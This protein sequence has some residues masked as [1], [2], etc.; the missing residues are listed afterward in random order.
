M[1]RLV[2]DPS[3]CVLDL[4]QVIN[5]FCKE[6][7]SHDLWSLLAPEPSKK[8]TWKTAPDPEWL[9]KISPFLIKLVSVVKNLVVASKK[10]K[11][12][13]VKIQPQEVSFNRTFFCSNPIFYFFNW[14]SLLCLLPPCPPV[15]RTTQQRL[16]Y[17]KMKDEQF[18]D[19]LDQYI[20]IGAAQIRT[21]KINQADFIRVAKK[22]SQEEKKAIE[23][24]LELVSVDPCSLLKFINFFFM[25]AMSLHFLV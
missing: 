20:R 13:M 10:L 6:K 23:E 4:Q 11:T 16:N 7:G 19:Q 22:C 25:I 18:F 1:G 24:I 17:S 8:V 9:H 5:Q 12:A 15:Q 14:I 2:P 21:L 3:V